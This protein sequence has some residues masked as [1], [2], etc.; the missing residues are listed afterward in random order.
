M[1]L[2]ILLMMAI[3]LLSGAAMAQP[4]SPEA[5]KAV[6]ATL[7]TKLPILK[8]DEVNATPIN[9]LYEVVYGTNLIYVTSD[10]RFL[11]RGD[12]VDLE[13]RELLTENRKRDLKQAKL[14]SLNEN[15]MIIYG[16]KDLP[17][18]VT[19]FTDIDCGYCRKLHSLIKEYNEEGIRIRYLAY[20]RSGI[21]REGKMTESAALAESVWCADDKHAA[22]TDAKA[23]KDVPKKNCNSPVAAQYQ[24]GQDFGV[25]GT[26]ALLFNDGKLV[27]GYVPP[28]RL[29]AALKAQ[30][31]R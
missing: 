20:P 28:K 7:A 24:L 12:I 2:I 30:Q 29:A 22:L 31:K 4:V 19:V 16:D 25:T 5:D 9:G 15:E 27:P 10:G 26:P 11:M 14:A 3:T 18:Q 13:S 1:R 21:M 23:G 17:F 6:R 8:I